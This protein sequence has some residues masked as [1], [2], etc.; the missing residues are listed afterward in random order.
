M[1]KL[2]YFDISINHLVW[3]VKSNVIEWEVG[4][5][6]AAAEPI[7]GALFCVRQSWWLSDRETPMLF[8]FVYTV[9]LKGTFGRAVMSSCVLIQRLFDIINFLFIEFESHIT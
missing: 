4:S 3:D 8:V 2:V 6:L 1:L 9:G 5:M 7:G